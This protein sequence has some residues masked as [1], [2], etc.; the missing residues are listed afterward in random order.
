MDQGLAAVLG[1]AVGVLGSTLASALAGRQ[2]ER[3]QRE[4]WRR[5]RRRDA[6]AAFMD[7]GMRM[8]HSVTDLH[9]LLSSPEENSEE[10]AVRLGDLRTRKD[11][12]DRLT[13]LVILEGPSEVSD[14]ADVVAADFTEL[15]N[16]LTGW[17]ECRQLGMSTELHRETYQEIID[18]IDSRSDEFMNKARLSLN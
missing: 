12:L 8:V 5:Q 16:C 18:R 1:A 10:A 3:S 7:H 14:L 4:H 9:S 15:R 13:V 2:Q 6:Y 17:L 11:E